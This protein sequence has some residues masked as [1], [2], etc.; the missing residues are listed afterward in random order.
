MS[1]I[2]ST[3]DLIMEKTKHLTMNEEEKKKYREKEI[4]GKVKGLV[5]RRLDGLLTGERFHKEIGALFRET[6]DEGAVKNLFRDEVADRL[7]LGRENEPLL[8]MLKT[9]IGADPEPVRTILYSYESKAALLRDSQEK[10]LREKLRKRGISG[11]A[12]VPN[13]E[14]DP[15]WRQALEDLRKDLKEELKA[16]TS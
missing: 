1:E 16:E 2:K 15:A 12:A 9:A 7:E 5:Q 13:L 10:T 8:D 14:A 4:A 6:E 11:P 3:L